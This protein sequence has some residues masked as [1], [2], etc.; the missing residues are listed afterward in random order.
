MQFK[1]I[2]SERRSY[3]SLTISKKD[4]ESTVRSKAKSIIKNDWTKEDPFVRTREVRFILGGKRML[5]P[6]EVHFSRGELAEAGDRYPI[7]IHIEFDTHKTVP[8]GIGHASKSGD[9]EFDLFEAMN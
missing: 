2:L 3:Q 4:I 9:V 8:I 7:M 5:S 1:T 6:V